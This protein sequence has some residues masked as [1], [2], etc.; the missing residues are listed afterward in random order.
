[1]KND[2]MFKVGDAVTDM[3]TKGGGGIVKKIEE[4]H[5][6]TYIGVQFPGE[7]RAYWFYPSELEKV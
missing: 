1:M 2:T 3:V 5:G 4:D 7:T 6:K